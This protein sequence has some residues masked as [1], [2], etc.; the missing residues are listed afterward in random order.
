[1]V[2]MGSPAALRAADM[3]QDISQQLVESV[4]VKIAQS[5]NAGE[6][7]NDP[8]E[9]LNRAI[10]DINE[11]IQILFLRPAGTLYRA[12][13]PLPVRTS[14]GNALDNLSSPIDLANDILQGEPERAW[15]T[16]QRLL[17]NST[18]GVAGLFDVAEKMGIPRHDEDFGQTLAVWGIG[19]GFYLVLPIFGPSNPRDAVG[20]LLVDGYFDPLNVWLDNSNRNAIAN[21]RTGAAGIDEY[22]GVMDELE[23]LQKTSIDYYSVLRSLYRQKRASEIKNGSDANL[24]PVP[25]L[26]YLDLSLQNDV[27]AS[28]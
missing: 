12:I 28:D 26:D 17:I 13:L 11:L 1:M 15:Q 5:S 18:L 9:L 20:K 4:S 7:V 10:F 3:P 23:N 8:M 6:D 27:S 25:D 14:V 21:A 19:E 22:E 2:L 16:T 24:P